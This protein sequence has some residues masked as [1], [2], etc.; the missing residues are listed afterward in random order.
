MTRSVQTAGTQIDVE[1]AVPWVGRLIEAAC[2]DA[3]SPETGTGSALVRVEAERRPFPTA[4]WALLT[5]G[6]WRRRGQVVVENVAASGFDLRLGIEPGRPVF[7]FRWRPPLR[8]RLA[9]VGLRH[10]F[11][12]LARAALLHYPALWWAG[13]LGRSPLHAAVCTAGP[14]VPLLA[15][16]GGVGKSTLMAAEIAAGGRV[17][18]DNVC[19]SDGRSAWGL[20]EP[21]RIAAAGG[22]RT[23]H[24]RVEVAIGGRLPCLE[25]DRVVVVRR[26]PGA[27]ARRRPCRAE[28]AARSLVT[29][30]YMAGELRRYWAVAAVLSDAT[31]LG[32]AHPRVEEVAAIL[33]ARL[34]CF[35]LA[36]PGRPPRT[37]V[38]LL[39]REEAP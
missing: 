32:P 7:A 8:E 26:G 35:E 4:G 31:G 14:T 20:V 33:A 3:L 29:G 1:C 12:L 13:V 11:V 36:L 10:R 25:P 30:T 19:V 23:T 5:R 27:A 18:T 38:R 37:P 9:S 6:A 39:Q 22:R 2:G 28:D 34:P 24:G 15:G 16:P 17:V 21:L